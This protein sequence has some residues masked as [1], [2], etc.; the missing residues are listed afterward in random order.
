MRPE[1]KESKTVPKF[2]AQVAHPKVT[3]WRTF[4]KKA[5]GGEEGKMRKTISSY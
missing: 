2:L 5:Y 1:R 3:E 4:Q